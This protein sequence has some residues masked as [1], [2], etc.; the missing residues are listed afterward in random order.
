MDTEWFALDAEGKI[1]L[2]DSDEGG[3]VP[4]SNQKIW[5]AA[6]I[7][8]VDMFF[9]E[10]AKAQANPLVYVKTPSTSLVD[11]LTFKTLQTQIDEAVNLAGQICG[12]RYGPERGQVTHLTWPTLEQYEL[13]SLLLLLESER[14]IPLLR[15]GQENLDNYIVRFTGEPVVVYMDRCQVLTIQKLVNR[16]M[17]L[18]GKALGIA[19]YPSATLFGFYCYNYSSFGAPAPYSRKGEPLFPICL[20]DLPEH[21]QDLISWT[22]FDD[23]KFSQCSVIQPIEHMKCSTWRNSKWWIDSHGREHKQHP[24]YKSH[25]IM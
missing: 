20:E 19:N 14:V 1:A 6:R 10:I 3:A 24:P 12:T 5:Q 9:S 8:S 23:L 7:D 25:Q 22:W 4:R 17:I 15:S 11:A 2:F 21:L 13:Y 16:G 18:A